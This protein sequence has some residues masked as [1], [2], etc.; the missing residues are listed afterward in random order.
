MTAM[1]HNHVTIIGQVTSWLRSSLPLFLSFFHG[2]PTLSTSHYVFY[3]SHQ[4]HSLILCCNDGIK[5]FQQVSHLERLNVL[6][7]W[8]SSPFR[9]MEGS[10]IAATQNLC[11]LS[12]IQTL[13]QRGGGSLC[14]CIIA[15]HSSESWVKFGWP[16]LHLVQL[17]IMFMKPASLL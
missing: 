11:H 1:W 13:P 4:P 8:S 3:Y 16:H 12:R 10:D 6:H 5:T 15:M 9:K 7:N 14:T 2:I 17:A